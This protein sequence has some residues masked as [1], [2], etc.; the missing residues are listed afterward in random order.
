MHRQAMEGDAITHRELPLQNTVLG[1]LGLEIGRRFKAA[2]LGGRVGFLVHKARR[3]EPAAPG[4]GTG[5]EFHT[6]IFFHRVQ[7]NPQA[8]DVFPIDR[9]IG[10]VMVPGRALFGTRL[11][12][13]HMLVVQIDFGRT[14]QLGG[15]RAGV[16]VEKEVPVGLNP[17]PVAVV[18]KK[19]TGVTGG[20]V[21]LG[22]GAGLAQILLHP[23]AQALNP[24]Q[25]D[26]VAQH[27]GAVLLVSCEGLLI[28][29]GANSWLTVALRV[30]PLCRKLSRQLYWN[31]GL[32]Q[33]L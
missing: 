1:P 6:G 29:H 27:R 8:D 9:V 20:R 2:V 16:G 25:A 23:L 4:M 13:Q 10:L 30:S 18:A 24:R 15:Q 7:R 33:P 22:V 26:D 21:V 12:H 19:H 17:L 31:A 3:R 11:F 28:K 5:D 14:H 32:L